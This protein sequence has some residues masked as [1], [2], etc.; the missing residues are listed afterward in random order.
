MMMMMMLMMI[1]RNVKHIKIVILEP[2]L[3]FIAL[4]MEDIIKG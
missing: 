4:A 1:L 3:Y 2:V